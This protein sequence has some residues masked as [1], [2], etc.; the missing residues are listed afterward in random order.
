MSQY[1]MM[2]SFPEFIERKIQDNDWF[3]V[4]GDINAL[5]DTIEFV[6]ANGKTEFLFEAKITITGHPNPAE[7]GGTDVF[8]T[9][10]NAVQAQLRLDTAVKDTA[11][12]G[13]VTAAESNSARWGYGNGY[14]INSDPFKVLGL[15]LVDDGAKKIEIVN[16]LDDGTDFATMS[17]WLSDT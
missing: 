15:S 12:V 2:A 17:G 3:Q 9:Q 10:R 16:T 7:Q 1:G 8:V 6:P 14:S 13:E 4:S 5:N 11:N